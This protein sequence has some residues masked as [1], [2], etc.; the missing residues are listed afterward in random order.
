MS[1][2]VGNYDTSRMYRSGSH[3]IHDDQWSLPALPAEV[4]HMMQSLEHGSAFVASSLRPAAS[5]VVAYS[6][7]LLAVADLPR[8][9]QAVLDLLRQQA[10]A[11]LAGVGRLAVEASATTAARLDDRAI[12]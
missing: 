2:Q 6:E 9:Q 4:A 12:A 7:Y 3:T 8:D 10:R 5:A 1:T 11:I